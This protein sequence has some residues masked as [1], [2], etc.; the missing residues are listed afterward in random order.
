MLTGCGHIIAG[1]SGGADSVCLLLCMKAIGEE[2]GITLSAVHVNHLLRGAES[3]SDEDFCRTLC[4][5]LHIPLSVY[6]VDVKGKVMETGMSVEQAARALRYD[7][8]LKESEKYPAAR[9][10]T[11]HNRCDNSETMLF[12]MARGTGVKGMCGIPYKRDNIIRPLLDLTRE[13]IEDFLLKQEQSFV[14]D[15]TNLC[16]DYSRNKLRH[17]VVP[18]MCGINRG[19]HQAAARLASSAREDEEYFSELIKTLKAEDI[20]SMAAAVRKRYIAALVSGSG[21]ECTYEMLCSLDESMKMKKSTKYNISGEYFAVFRKG[22]MTV[23]RISGKEYRYET[24]VDMSKNTEL[25]IVKFDKTVKISSVG[26]DIFTDSRN[27]HKKL[28][29]NLVN[30]GK[31]Q[32]AVVLRN[33]RDGD[34]IILKGREHS[35]RLKKLY[36]SMQLTAEQRAS[37]LVL[38]DEQGIIWSE[39]G[40]VC[41]RVCARAEQDNKSDILMISVSYS[42]T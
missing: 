16:D 11:A 27:I 28:T 13:E 5:K 42:K 7:A 12:N 37:A 40:G 32:G 38:E 1:L 26:D 23:E 39:Y 21:F 4:E 14:T 9:I 8:F 22:V 2:K 30:Y 29:N 17:S 18:V 36:N 33:K 6:R 19:F 10:A 31:I 20:P 24:A 41:E 35:T 25:Y 15:S 34:K 3:D